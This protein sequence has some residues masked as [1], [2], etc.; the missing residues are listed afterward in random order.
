M[1]SKL[2]LIG[3]MKKIFLIGGHV[4]QANRGGA[5]MCMA[6]IKILK[7][8]Y[9]D[10]SITVGHYMLD[11]IDYIATQYSKKYRNDPHMK[12]NI[13][14][15]RSKKD[16]IFNGLKLR[17]LLYLV[18]IW[19]L[20]RYM[21]IDIT[22][23]IRHDKILKQYLDA[24]IVIDLRWGDRFADVH[25]Y[26]IRYAIFCPHRYEPLIPI[27]LGRPYII[28]PQTIGPFCDRLTFEFNISKFIFDKAKVIM[29]REKTS[30]STM[31]K[32]GIPS[33]KMYLL[34]DIAFLLDPVSLE[35]VNNIF[36]KENIPT[37][38]PIVGI[39]LRIGSTVT[40][41]KTISPRD[42]ENYVQVMV[43][44]A[45]YMQKKYNCSI[46]LIPHAGIK[47][48]SFLYTDFLNRIKN[49][50]NIFCLQNR[51]YSTE[52]LRG[53]IGK[54]Y[55]HLSAYLHASV[56]SLS[57]CVP[58]I[59]FSYSDFKSKGFFEFADQEKYVISIKNLTLEEAKTKV[60]DLWNNREKIR[61]ELELKIP[62]IR[63]QIMFAGELTKNV[64]D[65]RQESK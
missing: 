18:I 44:I 45:I 10:A 5:T 50:K 4:F 58:A 65:E 37:N 26:G 38:F 64:L 36:K 57:M 55:I 59:N 63:R 62:E 14:K 27:I 25:R 21:K 33:K 12:L 34:P 28:F 35:D 30:M 11:S 43:D 48:E 40:G 52:E 41:K 19:K 24:D 8:Y 56:A 46:L 39:T 54:C 1:F 15:Q 60:E 61:K 32:I 16:I 13:P 22:K 51:E 31:L 3:K 23:V 9:P 42:D 49:N 47:S 7:T 29:V 2:L 6:A 53:I 20:L 17:F